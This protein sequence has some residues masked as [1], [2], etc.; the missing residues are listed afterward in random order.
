MDSN[1]YIKIFDSEKSITYYV[2]F[3]NDKAERQIEV[4]PQ[5]ILRFSQEW[6]D[7]LFDQSISEIEQEDYEVITKE[8]F[9]R[10]WNN[11]DIKPLVSFIPEGD[12]FEVENVHSYAHGCNCAG[13]MGRG[14]AAQF[15]E[16]YPAMYKE[17]YR[18]CK[19]GKFRPGDVYDYDYGNGHIY[20]LGTQET[21]QTKAK[22]EYIADALE[23]MLTLA[24]KDQVSAIA[25]PAIGAGLGGL[26][27]E[28]VK[29]TIKDV[30]RYH[31]SVDLFVV[32]SYKPC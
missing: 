3:R 19:E 28:D 9:E 12:I 22:L 10:L 32:E 21:W 15:K 1:T 6:N 24:E 27:W 8:D 25:L 4:Y 16:R 23:K 17:Y 29:V 14:I 5:R 31:P 18:L 11:P 2:H 30:A 26:K 20:N 13:A 7:I